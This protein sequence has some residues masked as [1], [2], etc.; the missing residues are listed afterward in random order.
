M[1]V[2]VVIFD[3]FG[4]FLFLVGAYDG[5]YLPDNHLNQGGVVLDEL[6][7]KLVFVQRGSFCAL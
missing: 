5:K 4:D 6:V 2:P 7:L 3:D 1:L